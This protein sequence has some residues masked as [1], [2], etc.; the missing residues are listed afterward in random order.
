MAASNRRVSGE[1]PASWREPGAADYVNGQVE[2]PTLEKLIWQA[3]VR[4]GGHGA[5]ACS[6]SGRVRRFFPDRWRLGVRVVSNR[7]SGPFAWAPAH[8]VPDP[9]ELPAGNPYGYFEAFASV[10]TDAAEHIRATQAGRDPEPGASM[11]QL[12]ADGARA[13]AFVEACL[14]SSSNHS[15]WTSLPDLAAKES[16]H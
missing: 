1:N 2:R 12:G 10:Y 14:E 7:H 3:G 9:S 8:Q 5:I 13:V 4:A 16:H 15:A 6:G 11:L